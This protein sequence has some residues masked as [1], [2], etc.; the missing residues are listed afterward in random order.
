[1]ACVLCQIPFYGRSWLKEG[2][3]L[4]Q[5]ESLAFKHCKR[6]YI[7]EN[8]DQKV[9]RAEQRVLIHRDCHKIIK[10]NHNFNITFSNISNHISVIL[11]NGKPVRVTLKGIDHVETNKYWNGDVFKSIEMQHKLPWTFDSPLENRNSAKF[12]SKCWVNYQHYLQLILSR[13]K[14]INSSNIFRIRNSI[15]QTTRSTMLPKNPNQEEILVR[16][17]TG[18]E[19]YGAN[20][21]WSIVAKGDSNLVRAMNDQRMIDR[22]LTES[23]DECR[24]SVEKIKN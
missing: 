23:M 13:S 5:S 2:Y 10:E 9:D 4:N 1:M 15:R 11:H 20:G 16:S 24:Q 18:E 12:R 3:C 8:S 21:K 7:I 6:G 17:S 22:E 19:Y 14:C